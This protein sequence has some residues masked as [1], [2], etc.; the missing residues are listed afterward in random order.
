M[1]TY[2][3]FV[4]ATV[5][6]LGTLNAYAA[7]AAKTIEAVYKDKAKL[8]GKQVTVKGNVVK[9]NNGIMGRNFLHIQ[10][11]TGGKDNNDL[12]VTSAQTAQVGD[13]VTISGKVTLNKDFGAGYTYPLIVE[14][15]TVTPAK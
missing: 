7:D 9:V 15:A 6:G 3:A 1:K 10:D 11:G 8:D 5:L 13:K 2:T 4:L 14:E 12:S